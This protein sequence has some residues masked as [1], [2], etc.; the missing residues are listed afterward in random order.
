MLLC[1]IHGESE[2]LVGEVPHLARIRKQGVKSTP[3]RLRRREEKANHE[4]AWI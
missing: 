1:T 4:K 2:I 3:I